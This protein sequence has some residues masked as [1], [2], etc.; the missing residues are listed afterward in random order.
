MVRI[1]ITHPWTPG[2]QGLIG[3]VLKS[4]IS[5]LRVLLCLYATA[6]GL[7]LNL[8][9]YTMHWVSY[10]CCVQKSFAETRQLV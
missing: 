8:G 10:L 6:A 9:K 3:H 1:L 5:V 4:I 2:K 7:G